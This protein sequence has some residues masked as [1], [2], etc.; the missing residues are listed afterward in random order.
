MT[1]LYLSA[2]VAILIHFFRS[3]DRR[4]LLLDLLLALRAVS[5]FLGHGTWSAVADAGTVATALVLGY[6]LAPRNQ[7][8]AA[9][10]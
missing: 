2:T 6:T 7:G 3:R 8:S 4:L 9:R 5:L 10:P 1:A